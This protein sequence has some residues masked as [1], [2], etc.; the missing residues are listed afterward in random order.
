MNFYCLHP[1]LL[2][3]DQRKEADECFFNFEIRYLS[4]N[5][6]LV[7][8]KFCRYL[9]IVQFQLDCYPWIIFLEI[10]KHNFYLIMYSWA[11]VKHIRCIRRSTGAG[12]KKVSVFC[13]FLF[14]H[15]VWHSSSSRQRAWIIWLW[16]VFILLIVLIWCTSLDNLSCLLSFFLARLKTCLQITCLTSTGPILASPPSCLL[17]L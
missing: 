6:R 2:S 7:L 13:G 8:Y 15:L 3:F 17:W 14:T 10:I 11:S 5:L 16:E 9:D 4:T 12:R 1:K